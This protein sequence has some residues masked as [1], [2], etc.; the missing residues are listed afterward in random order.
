MTLAS[1]KMC[2]EGAILTLASFKM[3][4]ACELALAN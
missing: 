3:G 1:F 2:I 4:G